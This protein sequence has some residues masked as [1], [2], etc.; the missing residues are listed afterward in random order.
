MTL[1]KDASACSR[2]AGVERCPRTPRSGSELAEPV[3]TRREQ[4]VIRGRPQGAGKVATVVFRRFRFGKGSVVRVP[5]RCPVASPGP[6]TNLL[7]LQ[8]VDLWTF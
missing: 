1:G 5:N 6:R 7:G 3:R 2:S 4:R 8:I